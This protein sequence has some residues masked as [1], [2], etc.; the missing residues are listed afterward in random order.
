MKKLLIITLLT[1]LAPAIMHANNKDRD[2]DRDRRDDLIVIGL[3]SDNRLVWFSEDSPKRAHT[4]GKI[5]G[6]DGDTQ[7]GRH[8]LPGAGRDA[9]RRRQR[10]RRLHD[11]TST[12]GGH[13][14]EHS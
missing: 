4:I 2:P 12:R 13:Q 9:L 11:R 6:L 8:R 3:T 5:T 14:V 7:P 10:R 1:A